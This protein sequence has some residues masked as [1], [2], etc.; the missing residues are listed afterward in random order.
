MHNYNKHRG[1]SQTCR[2]IDQRDD[3]RGSRVFPIT[4]SYLFPQRSK[5]TEAEEYSGSNNNKK[6]PLL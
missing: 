3:E 5:R 2:F 1:L 4:R 6:V